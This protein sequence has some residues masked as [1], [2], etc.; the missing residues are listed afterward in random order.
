MLYSNLSASEKAFWVDEMVQHSGNHV[1]VSFIVPEK[2]DLLRVAEAIKLVIDETPQF[3]STVILQGTTPCWQTE[4]QYDYPIKISTFK[5]DCVDQEIERFSSRRFDLSKDFPCLFRLLRGQ[6][7]HLLLFLFHH[8]VM[9]DSSMQLFCAKIST[10]YNQL[11]AGDRPRVHR[12][13][14]SAGTV[15]SCAE[16]DE[17]ESIAFWN[18]YVDGIESN[19]VRSYFPPSLSAGR[20]SAFHF[21]FSELQQS[22]HQLCTDKK[23]GPFRLLAAA[24]AVTVLKVFQLPRVNINYPISMRPSE[25]KEKMGVFINEQI[26]RVCA[27]SETPFCDIVSAVTN[28]RRQSRAHQHIS[29]LDTHVADVI[30]GG[31]TIAFNYPLGLNNVCLQFSDE[32]VPLYR[33]PLTYMPSSLQLDVEASIGYGYIYANAT[34]PS[35]FPKILAD[36]FLSILHQVVDDYNVKFGHLTLTCQEPRPHSALP[37]QPH[38]GV[39]IIWEFQCTAKRYPEKTAVIYGTE[40]ISYSQLDQWSDY[41]AVTILQHANGL[42]TSPFVGVYTP[43][44]IHTIA[45]LLGVIKSGYAYIPMDTVYS[46]ERLSYV[47]SDSSL[48]MIVADCDVP[49]IEAVVVKID[50]QQA[51][52]CHEKPP[53]PVSTDYAYM[54]YTSGT[55]G[56]PKGTPITQEALLCLTMSRQQLLP[57]GE[58]HVELCFSSISFDASVWSIFP[59]LL[60]GATICMASDEE[61]HDTDALLRLLQKQHITCALLPPTILTYLPYRELADLKYLVTGGDTCPQETIERWQQTTT[62][63]NAYGPTENTVVSTLHVFNDAKVCHTNIGQPLPHVDCYVLDEHL[64]PVP[65]GVR[66]VLYLGGKQLTTGYWNRQELNRKMFIPSPFTNQGNR[67]LLYN[68][69]DVVCRM[70]NGDI[71]FMGRNDQ[72]VKIRG[73]RIELAEIENTLMQHPGVHQCAVTVLHQG[74][75]KQL[76]AYVGADDTQLSPR[77]LRA[78]LSSHLPPYMLPDYWYVAPMLPVNTSGKIDHGQLQHLQLSRGSHTDVNEFNTEEE[79]KCKSLL[80]KVID[81]P[82]S[83]IGAD[84]NLIRDLGVNSLDILNLAYAFSQRGYE[85]RPADIYQQHTIRQLAAFLHSGQS[86][87]ELTSRQKDDRVCYF[88]NANDSKKPL[89]LIICGYRYYEI[90]YSDF[91][92]TLKDDYSILVLESVIETRNYYPEKVIDAPTLI[93]EYVRL[94]RPI[95]KERPIAGITGLCIGGDL[96]LQLAV[97]LKELQLGAP[98]VFNIDGMANRP[99]FK[100]QMG[101]MRGVGITKEVDEKRKRFT[102]AFA[103]TI[104]QYHYDGACVLFVATRFEDVEDFKKEDA[105]AFYP[106]NLHNWLQA[107]PD[108]EIIFIDDVHMQLIHHKDSLRKIKQTMDKRMI[109]M[110]K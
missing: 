25:M 16:K 66:G 55:T 100:A 58:G 41:V 36:C 57:Y 24:W 2:V 84:D 59:S 3:H 110:P 17:Q 14:D 32:R 108:M 89:L 56:N 97:R 37:L 73:F 75:D 98:C 85:V 62:V 27:D 43:R 13:D 60:S 54:I 103:S 33:R 90:N 30:R 65:D 50:W 4:E 86:N 68:S 8:I 18:N 9:E 76:A 10:Y 107:Q 5:D 63:V 106:Q 26:L 70:P 77:K 71:L 28:D 53:P 19:D 87:T 44:S 92:N 34:Y 67:E 21:S 22:L 91:H 81:I 51:G 79:I 102:I 48:T 99:D 94:L 95:L 42:P 104:P 64:H 12:V 96:A 40:R 105:E 35:F 15:A 109:V 88:A 69:G 6:S 93:D 61:R 74:N 29:M 101:V 7:R 72:Q 38:S 82:F 1:L 20:I 39:S 45:M 23:V 46:M 31:G 80:S 49:P 83:Q 47:V 52:Q 78:F 11:P